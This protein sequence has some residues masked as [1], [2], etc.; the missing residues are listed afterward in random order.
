MRSVYIPAP[1]MSNHYASWTLMRR[2]P[3]WCWGM[4]DR[5]V[6]KLPPNKNWKNLCVTGWPSLCLGAH[7]LSWDGWVVKHSFEKRI[8]RTQGAQCQRRALKLDLVETMLK[9]PASLSCPTCVINATDFFMAFISKIAT[10][11]FQTCSVKKAAL[12]FDILGLRLLQRML[13]LF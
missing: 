2:R 3:K 4:L 8:G 1:F 6:R 10:C 5:L 7:A 12:R 9:I 11:L 13:V